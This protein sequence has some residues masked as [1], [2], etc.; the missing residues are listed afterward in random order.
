VDAPRPRVVGVI[1]AY[2]AAA[3]LAPIVAGARRRLARVLVVDDGS[4]DATAGVAAAAGAEVHR[5]AVN[6]GKG[7]ALRTAF[8]LLLD[9][10]RA[11]PDPDAA[12]AAA[13][14]IDADGQHDPDDVPRFLELFERERPAV[15]IGSRA[16]GFARMWG[17]RR[18]M[19]RFSSFSLRLLAGI[20]LPDSQS[21]YRLYDARFLERAR[22]GGGR[23]EAEMGLLMQA[24]RLHLPVRSIDIGAA[25]ADGRSTSHYRPIRDTFRIVGTVLRERLGRGGGRTGAPDPPGP[26]RGPAAGD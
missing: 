21:G 16:W 2:Q 9:E 19:N 4:R 8:R 22:L 5:H 11:A 10:R 3:T 1:P 14:T 25:V 7:A 23:Y 24:A 17:P 15:V 20:D 13:L 12:F 6:L 18:A 26:P